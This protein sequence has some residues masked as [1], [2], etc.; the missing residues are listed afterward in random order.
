MSRAHAGT[1]Y[2]LHHH[3]GLKASIVITGDR[4]EPNAYNVSI[5]S[6]GH[7]HEGI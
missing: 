2:S 6:V 5:V 3:E 4:H 7:N 1:K